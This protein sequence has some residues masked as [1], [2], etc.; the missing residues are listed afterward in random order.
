MKSDILFL[1]EKM[2]SEKELTGKEAGSCGKHDDI[3]SG[4]QWHIA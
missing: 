4:Q 2:N 1:P 3:E